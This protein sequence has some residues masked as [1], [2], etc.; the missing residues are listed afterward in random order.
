MG[1]YVDYLD[2]DSPLSGQKWCCISFL[3]PEGIKNCSVRGLKIR[4]VFS[5]KKEADDRATYLQSVDPD[6]DVFVGEIGKWLPWDPDPN[7]EDKVKDQQYQEQQLNDLMKGYKDNLQKSKVHQEQ[8]KRDMIEKASVPNP[9]TY[10]NSSNSSNQNNQ[11]RDRLKRKLAK[12][13]KEKTKEEELKKVEKALIEEKKLMNEKKEQLTQRK[14]E[15]DSIDDKLAKIQELYN[16]MK[17]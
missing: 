1:K 2:E 16:K 17:M 11:T 15:L 14:V 12:K 7:D 6:F 9:E 3:S 10:N 13:N 4:G 5:T 8:R